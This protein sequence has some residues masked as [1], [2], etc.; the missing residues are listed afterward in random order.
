ME[1]DLSTYRGKNAG[2]IPRTLYNL[3]DQLEKDDA[4]YSVRVSVKTKKKTT[5]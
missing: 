1:G 5:T 3:F 4:E 2:I